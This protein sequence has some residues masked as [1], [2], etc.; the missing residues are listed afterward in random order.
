MFSLFGTNGK[1]LLENFN[2]KYKKLKRLSLAD[3]AE[4]N[5]ETTWRPLKDDI[6][7]TKTYNIVTRL[8]VENRMKQRIVS[9]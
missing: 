9:D 6:F 2:L 4:Q 3:S 1:E 5:N 7:H 8:L